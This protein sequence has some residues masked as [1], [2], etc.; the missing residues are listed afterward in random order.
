MW[1]DIRVEG[2]KRGE[3]EEEKWRDGAGGGESPSKNIVAFSHRV[4]MTGHI[5]VA[6]VVVHRRLD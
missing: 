3:E 2:G 1:L 6:C 4:L 5:V